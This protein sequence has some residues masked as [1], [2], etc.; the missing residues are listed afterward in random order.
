MPIEYKD[1]YIEMDREY[2]DQL[3]KLFGPGLL[4]F[5][6]GTDGARLQMQGQE[7]KQC[8][9]ILNPDVARVSTHYENI[10]GKLGWAY[11]QLRGT[12]RVEAKIV[13]FEGFTYTLVLYNIDTDTYDMI[14]KPINENPT[15]RY[16]FVYNT[17]A[18]DKLEVGDTITDEI[19]YKSTSYDKNMN[20]RYGKNAKVYV[21]SSPDVLE[22]AIRIRKG[23][24]R[25][26]LF[27]QSS[28]YKIPVS[29]NN[30]PINWYGDNNVFQGFP[31]LGQMCKDNIVCAIR[32]V[33][34]KHVRY[35]FQTENLQKLMNID[36]E[37]YAP[38]NS[39]LTDIEVFYDDEAEFPSNVF[40][41]Q[42]KEYYDANCNYAE[43]MLE[44]S[45]RIKKS[46]SNYTENVTFF[47]S[48]YMHYNDP[49]YK[50]K[51][52]GSILIKLKMLSV[53]GMDPGSKGSGRYGD[54]GVI[55]N[56]G[57]DPEEFDNWLDEVE[58]EENMNKLL[59]LPDF[60]R[61]IAEMKGMV[62]PSEEELLE[63][64]RKIIITP[65]ASMHYTDH[66]PVDI[67]LNA[68]GAT[69]RENI[70]QLY[71]VDFNFCSWH[72]QQKVKSLENFEDKVELIFKYLNLIEKEEGDFF[73]Q[74]FQ[75][76]DRVET[77]NNHRI[78]LINRTEQ[79]KFV[80]NIEKHG[81]YIVRTIDSKM[82]YSTL[83]KILEE[84][85]F[86]KPL[87]IYVDIFGTKKRRVINDGIVADKYI[88]F[89]I[90]NNNKNFSARSTFRLNRSNLPTK[91]AAKRTGRSPY[92]HNPVRLGEYYNLMSDI[93]GAT[94]A[95]MNIPMRS[96]VLAM[97]DLGKIL[98]N[99]GNPLA[100]T[101]IRIKED[102]VNANAQIAACKLKA[103]GIKLRFHKDNEESYEVV[104]DEIIPLHIDGY[105]IYDTPLNKMGYV[106]IFKEY[107]KY[108]NDAV[109][110]ESY[111]GEK[112]DMAWKHV[113]NLDEVKEMDFL[114]DDLKEMLV[115]V[116]KAKHIN[117]MKM[118]GDLSEEEASEYITPE[119]EKYAEEDNDYFKKKKKK[120]K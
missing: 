118:R 29:S 39:I 111:P 8:L 89:L 95:E 36:T 101:K 78:R 85:P 87:P 41:Q 37:Y 70:D 81:F 90:H 38:D 60:L 30:V 63:I 51:D 80:A 5:P 18:M 34:K 58:L 117:S 104:R 75:S 1:A 106:T 120:K 99:T 83:E 97:K 77:I 112:Q 50:W 69:R 88:M 67:T 64:R 56:E 103:L 73:L 94:L 66:F 116:T 108:L 3:Y 115:S 53:D 35:D 71:E 4:A 55:S 11:K 28:I 14:E 48:K 32:P 107:R 57:Q 49:E 82:R 61:E 25:K 119:I 21:I 2:T 9:N 100:V 42:L 65:D 68:G 105:T 16:A 45:T 23:W 7:V 86:I 31:K 44:W 24:L 79:E 20:Y 15:E 43:Q 76:W 113:F 93:S 46:G 22:D 52:K 102:Y 109:I 59:D 96:S 74:L 62:D 54:K 19:L 114:T 92:S 84:F 47:R 98:E 10:F 6:V 72:I 110:V 91:D 33:K 26:I 27:V 13:K 40:F 17:N 12:W